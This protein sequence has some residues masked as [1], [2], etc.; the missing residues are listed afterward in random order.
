MEI[1]P[2]SCVRCN[3]TTKN[4][5]DMR[6][7]LYERKKMCPAPNPDN[8]IEMTDEI[9]EKIL[10]NRRYTIPLKIKEDKPPTTIQNIHYNN[11]MNNYVKNMDCLDKIKKYINYNDIDLV[12]I[13][14]DLENKFSARVN[15]LEGNK[16]K[17][18]YDI[19]ENRLFDIIEE[20]CKIRRGDFKKLNI[21]Y[22]DKLKELNLFK[23][24]SWETVILDRGL[25]EIVSLLQDYFLNYYEK[26]L[27]MKIYCEINEQEK[28]KYRED[29]ERHYK[30]LG[31]FD[32]PPYIKDKN[33]L[34][35]LGQYYKE[36]PDSF[37]DKDEKEK[38]ILEE[39]WLKLYNNT[40]DNTKKCD[41][42][43]TKKN[44]IEI[45]K[46]NTKRNMKE[47]NIKVIELLNIDEEFKQEFKL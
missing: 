29:L 32:L 46:N 40:V 6:K 45:L 44:I 31:C 36:N 34:E 42:N 28:M 26:Y 4:K 7:H 35:I 16:F 21:V 17:F 13:E 41:I 1:I 22:D 25:R 9:K 8:D 5:K 12:S 24:G 10:L 3:Y 27:I 23:S 38:Y 47:L 37:E 20:I 15:K 33:D 18:G 11:T 2:Y 14:D 30:L 39:K 19:D 43:K